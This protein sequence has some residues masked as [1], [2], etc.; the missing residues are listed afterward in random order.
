M[1]V[2]VPEVWG[3]IPTA[4]RTANTLMA[5]AAITMTPYVPQAAL[6]AIFTLFHPTWAATR[7]NAWATIYNVTLEDVTEGEDVIPAYLADQPWM[8]EVA[9]CQL[10]EG[11]QIGEPRCLQLTFYNSP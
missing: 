8:L 7:E 5:D 9:L 3:C 1:A 2:S 4:E 11:C 10:A 6:S